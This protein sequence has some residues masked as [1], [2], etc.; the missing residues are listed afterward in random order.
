MKIN[1]EPTAGNDYC[2]QKGTDENGNHYQMSANQETVSIR[3]KD[4]FIGS[5]WTAEEALEAAEAE[6]REALEKHDAM[7]EEFKVT[8][9]FDYQ[10]PIH[11][12]GCKVDHGSEPSDDIEQYLP[13]VEITAPPKSSFESLEYWHNRAKGIWPTRQVVITTRK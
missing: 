13:I 3:T 4:G 8:S 7:L 12:S 2:I 6:R 9:V 11:G 5:G 1:W 10:C